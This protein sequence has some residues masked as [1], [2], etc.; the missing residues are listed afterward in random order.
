MYYP[1]FYTADSNF[2]LAIRDDATGESILD[3]VAHKPF[4]INIHCNDG[5]VIYGQITKIDEPRRLLQLTRVIDSQTIELPLSSIRYLCLPLPI[6]PPGQPSA[7]HSRFS[8]YRIYLVD[9]T[10]LSGIAR[11]YFE[12]DHGL[13]IWQLQPG[14]IIRHVFVLHPAIRD[15]QFS[16]AR[17]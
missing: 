9:N 11:H 7:P 3:L 13:H 12:D 5:R 2:C 1:N 16:A 6:Q 15:A 4:Y 17:L 8:E 10:C 14:D